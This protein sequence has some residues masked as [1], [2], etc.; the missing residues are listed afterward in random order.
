MIKPQQTQTAK[1]WV[2]AIATCQRLNLWRALLLLVA[3]SHAALAQDVKQT[4]FPGFRYVDP[5]SLEVR[6]ASGGT[7][8]LLADEDFAPWSFLGADGKLKGI[9]VEVA[10]QA[11]TTAGLT[12]ELR[13]LPFAGL[14]PAVRQTAGAQGIVSGLKL[15]AQ[16]ATEFA[17]TR[18]YF[19]T[20]GRFAIR[21]GS[22]LA[23][24]DIRTLAGRRIGFRANT[25]HARFLE[26][27]Y[28]RSALTPFDTTDAM[29]EALR[30]G[31]VDAVFGDALQMSF[32]LSGQASRGCCSFLGKAFVHRDTF[33]RSLSF[34]LRRDDPQ[35][36]AR[37]DAALDQMESKGAIAEIFARYVPASLW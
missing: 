26:T 1:W 34:V 17:V 4:V 25:A 18:P 11:C 21:T 24:P 6:P 20:L 15:D 3:I 10:A 32:W 37:L 23:A 28:A 12:C 35:W 5:T 33:S 9:S 16:I 7:I 2:K 29:L 36:R 14:L 19:Y 22:S 27:Y 13:A 30:T 31:Q 8:V